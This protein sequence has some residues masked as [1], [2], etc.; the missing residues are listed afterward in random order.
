MKPPI[1][2]IQ[3]QKNLPKTAVRISNMQQMAIPGSIS[4]SLKEAMNIRKGFALKKTSG[5]IAP[6]KG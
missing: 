6:V 3:P 5:G 1:G 4:R 2:Q